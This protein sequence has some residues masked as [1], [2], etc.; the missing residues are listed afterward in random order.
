MITT[1]ELI[2]LSTLAHHFEM[3]N[4]ESPCKSSSGNFVIFHSS[5]TRDSQIFFK[6]GWYY[7]PVDFDKWDIYSRRYRTHKEALEAAEFWE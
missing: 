4:L 7:E 3:E 6:D 5:Q 1:N 2:P